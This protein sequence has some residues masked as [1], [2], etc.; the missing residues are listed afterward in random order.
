[1]VRCAVAPASK[2]LVFTVSLR[3][4][5]KY[6][7]EQQCVSVIDIANLTMRCAVAPVILVCVCVAAVHKLMVRCAVAPAS[8]V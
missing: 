4:V 5:M 7:G 1:M 3:C 2:V 8:K 6:G